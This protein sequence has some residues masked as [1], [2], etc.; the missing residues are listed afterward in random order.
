MTKIIKKQI[1]IRLE[2]EL[3]NFLVK[4]AEKN[5]TNISSLI[6]HFIVDIYQKEQMKKEDN[7]EN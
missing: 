2:L 5:F 7:N 4:F 1:N 6:R 3:Y